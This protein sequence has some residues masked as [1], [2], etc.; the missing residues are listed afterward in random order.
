MDSDTESTGNPGPSGVRKRKRESLEA[1]R[2]K[3]KVRKRRQRANLPP[4]SRQVDVNSPTSSSESSSN[5]ENAGN[6]AGRLYLYDAQALQRLEQKVVA[7]GR[8]IP[9]GFREFTSAQPQ[10]EGSSSSSGGT[11][12]AQEEDRLL[13]PAYDGG[14]A[15]DSTRNPC[16]DGGN[17]AGED[18]VQSPEAESSQ[19]DFGN[20]EAGLGSESE[21]IPTTSESSS[22]EGGGTAD[23]HSASS[24]EEGGGQE[25]GTNRARNPRGNLDEEEAV[26]R[27]KLESLTDVERLARDM[28]GV[29]GSSKATNS[30]IDKMF[31]VVFKHMDTVRKLRG[32]QGKRK[33]TYSKY[34]RRLAAKYVPVIT[35][36]LLLEEKTPEG[37]IEYRRLEGLTAIPEEYRQL[38]SAGV[39]RIIREESCVSLQQ[40]K[41]HHERV[42]VREGFRL[43]DIRKQYGNCVLSLDGVEESKSGQKKFHVA[44]IKIGDCIY[45]Y[46]VYDF[47]IG[48][49]AAKICTHTMLG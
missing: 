7:A 29:R 13:S 42:H 32:K 24:G 12:V 38:Q 39:L 17:E 31:S 3:C 6:P 35:T 21:E 23:E 36:D 20:Q 10:E 5:T 25:D 27:R 16:S 14:S 2:H 37:G 8:R 9:H 26:I 18:G 41:E 11:P 4:L 46:K 44:S 15:T 33:K 19:R 45:P 28:A 34:L 40:I 22:D 43:E 1:R 47:T 48:H 30:A 49:E